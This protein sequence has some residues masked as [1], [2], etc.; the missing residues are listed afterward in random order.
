MSESNETNDIRLYRSLQ[1]VLL[2]GRDRP[3]PEAL[4]AMVDAV[5]VEVG[6]ERAAL[7]Y[8]LDSTATRL[9]VVAGVPKPDPF[10]EDE[11]EIP[12]SP[13]ARVHGGATEVDPGPDVGP[14]AI[15][16]EDDALC[17]V[18]QGFGW[19]HRAYLGIGLRDPSGE[20][21]G[22]LSLCFANPL[23]DPAAR[24]SAVAL[25]EMIALKFQS[26]LKAYLEDTWRSRLLQRLDAGTAVAEIDIDPLVRLGN[27]RRFDARL[28]AAA[29]NHATTGRSYGLLCVDLDRFSVVNAALGHA[30]GDVVL[31]AVARCLT[32]RTRGTTEQVFRCGEDR[33]LILCDSPRDAWGLRDLADRLVRSIRSMEAVTPDSIPPV[34]ASIGGAMARG[35]DPTGRDVVARAEAALAQAK[36]AGRDRAYVDTID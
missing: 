12:G 2:A 27:Q 11:L 8:V 5:F 17:L 7:G 16:I 26:V 9:R 18:R 23:A 20:L 33:F 36:E 3:V 24:K 10:A 19:R 6:A 13:L 31:R 22:S 15:L 30:V 28:A 35:A 1:R 4:Q 29:D 14:R 34:T 21:I 25:V 32:H